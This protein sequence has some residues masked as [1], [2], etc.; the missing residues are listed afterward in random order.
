[1]IAYIE[2]NILIISR[3]SHFFLT[4]VQSFY[5]GVVMNAI[6]L[7]VDFSFISL[8][9]KWN[10]FSNSYMFSYNLTHIQY[11]KNIPLHSRG[12]TQAGRKNAF[13]IS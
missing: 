1:M 10:R 4:F 3:Y 11:N 7:N 2:Y 6:Y 8:E 12:R 5:T 9:L 13:L